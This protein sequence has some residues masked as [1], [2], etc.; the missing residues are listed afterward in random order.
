MKAIVIDTRNMQYTVTKKFPG[1]RL[2][3]KKLEAD[4]KVAVGLDFGTEENSNFINVLRMCGF[5]TRF[6][7]SIIVKEGSLKKTLQNEECTLLLV[8]ELFRVSRKTDF[9]TIVSQNKT[10]VPIIHLLK[11][12]GIFIEVLG[13]GIPV[14]LRRACDHWSEIKEEDLIKSNQG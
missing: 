4:R 11:S 6:P 2:N 1:S 9:I 13:A 3:Y 5:E 14:E 10:L 7:K 8:S 12:L